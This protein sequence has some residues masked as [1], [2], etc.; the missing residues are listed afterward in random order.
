MIDHNSIVENN[1]AARYHLGELTDTE[2]DAYEEHY[3]D[4]P[5]C[6]EDM[7]CV[8]EF[9]LHGR[10][11]AE[12]DAAAAAAGQGPNVPM[13]RDGWNRSAWMR[14]LPAGWPA[15]AVAVLVLMVGLCTYQIATQSQGSK[16]AFSP[17]NR[18][19]ALGSA[20]EEGV[21]QMSLGTNELLTLRFKVPDTISNSHDFASLEALILSESG[22]K[23]AKLE[24]SD[25]M[26][27]DMID[28]PL[29]AGAL[30]SGSY[31]LVFV[32]VDRSGVRTEV[33]GK[34]NR[35]SFKVEMHK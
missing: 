8:S 11:V 15:V 34:A 19:L 10:K 26:M 35:F 27:Q 20:R 31:T 1:F 3:F 21:P 6:A 25:A 33:E 7:L 4:C 18:I 23:K 30:E 28:W 16:L 14:I 2:C 32:Q 24:I 12:Q 13:A 5:E 17:S 9:M 22:A 29:P